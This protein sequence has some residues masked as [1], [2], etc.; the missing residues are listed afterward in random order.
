MCH[1][2]WKIRSNGNSSDW[3]NIPVNMHIQ[4]TYKPGDTF[5][6]CVQGS[7]FLV[8]VCRSW[9]HKDL[10]SLPPNFNSFGVKGLGKMF[11]WRCPVG[12]MVQSQDLAFLKQ[13]VDFTGAPI[14]QWVKST[15]MQGQDKD[16]PVHQS[17]SGCLYSVWTLVSLQRNEF[18]ALRKEVT[19]PC[20]TQFRLSTG[21][22]PA[23]QFL[24]ASD[25]GFIIKL[26]CSV[27]SHWLYQQ[28]FDFAYCL[29]ISMH[30]TLALKL[31]RLK[32]ECRDMNVS[33]RHYPEPESSISER[34]GFEG[35]KEA[36]SCETQPN[37]CRTKLNPG[38]I[39]LK[40]AIF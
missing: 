6:V 33:G 37:T 32:E 39:T 17:H 15:I 31:N 8:T 38:K 2:Q 16:C 23:P 14:Y 25:S 20:K 1:Q 34:C 36:V 13:A 10:S 18:S 28:M 24:P 4:S 29:T 26:N 19:T 3:A 21:S 7:L 11:F 22:S 27:F 30:L 9:Q 35:R 12:L 5:L 40:S